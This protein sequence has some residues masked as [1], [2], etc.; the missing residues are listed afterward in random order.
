MAAD[1]QSQQ[2]PVILAWVH[3]KL[4]VYRIA[5]WHCNF[6]ALGFSVRS[7]YLQVDGGSKKQCSQQSTA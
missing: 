6:L 7:S 2:L 4:S 1:V 3:L 5:Q